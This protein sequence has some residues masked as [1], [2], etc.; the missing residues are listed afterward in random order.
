M[1]TLKDHI[2]EFE[3]E[4][5]TTK[6]ATGGGSSFECSDFEGMYVDLKSFF[7]SSLR[8]AIE[9]AL[10]ECRPPNVQ[11]YPDCNQWECSC[12]AVNFNAMLSDYDRNVKDFLK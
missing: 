10:K 3:K 8:S 7:S 9:E 4:F 11:H 1:K 12:V 5:E 2:A 6:F